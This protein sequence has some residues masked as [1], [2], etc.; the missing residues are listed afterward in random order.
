[1]IASLTGIITHAEGDRIILQTAG[2]VGYAITLTKTHV[3]EL[4]IGKEVAISTY[5]RVTD[6]DH[7]LFGFRTENDRT[8]FELLISVSGVGPKSAMNILGLGSID[9]IQSAIAREDVKYLTAVQG[10]G[11]K[12]AERLVVE[13]NAKLKKIAGKN[14]NNKPNDAKFG[15]VMGETI[16]A[17]VS[18]GYSRE[19]AK[20]AIEYIDCKE[21]TVE[22]ILKESLKLL[23]R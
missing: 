12:T 18:M 8:F 1:M 6:S 11:K 3:T 19:E 23:S 21:K 13:L 16:D 15:E 20:S 7:S 4:V 22:Q 14:S 2:G 9:D 10:L 5:L 17:L